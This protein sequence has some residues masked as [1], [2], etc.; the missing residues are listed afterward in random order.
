MKKKYPINPTPRQLALIKE[1]WQRFQSV[2]SYY[3]RSI[4]E[5]EREMSKAVK[6]KNLEFFFCDNECAGVGQYDR[7]M[8]L[9]QRDVLENREALRGGE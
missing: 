1:Y 3:Y 8:K 9:I 6:I 5:L 7:K 4:G 2:Q